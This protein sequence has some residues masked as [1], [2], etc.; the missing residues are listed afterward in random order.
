MLKEILENNQF[1]VL[2]QNEERLRSGKYSQTRQSEKSVKWLLEAYMNMSSMAKN[3]V[4]VPVHVSYDRVFEQVNLATE[5][6][7]GEN[8]AMSG[9]QVLRELAWHENGQLGSVYVKYLEP[10]PIHDYLVKNGYEN[11]DHEHQEAASQKLT[12]SLLKQQQYASPVTLNSIIAAM[13]LFENAKTI[14]MVEILEFS[15]VIY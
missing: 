12:A 15:D 10:I 13:L 3:L 9:L 11:L 2:F 8:R 14:K 1:T 6:I 7:S 5:M 4:I